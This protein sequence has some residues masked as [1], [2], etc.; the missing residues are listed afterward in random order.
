M[1]NTRFIVLFIVCYG[2]VGTSSAQE[3]KRPQIQQSSI[4]MDNFEADGKLDEWKQPLQADNDD[5]KLQYSLAND[6]QYL[7]LAVKSNRTSKI[8]NGGIT[9][10]VMTPK[11][12]PVSII[13]PYDFTYDRRANPEIV[14]HPDKPWNLSDLKEIEIDGIQNVFTKTIPI[15]NEYGIHV[16]ISSNVEYT[17]LY[18]ED[19]ELYYMVEFGI[20]LEYFDI[21]LVEGESKTLDYKLKLRGIIPPATFVGVSRG[22]GNVMTSDGRIV[23]KFSGAQIEDRYNKDVD[24]YRPS[25]L[26][27]TYRLA[28]TQE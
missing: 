25:E 11:K 8:F 20:P 5:T 12:Q 26:K 16:G 21:K 17:E 9:L 24:L 2:V 3:E 14:S 23:Q 10:E 4:W 15:I 27:G 7:Y 18:K 13:F 6:N 22:T 19:G 1:M 28:T